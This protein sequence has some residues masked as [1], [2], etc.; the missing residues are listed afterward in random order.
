[1]KPQHKQ[2]TNQK[3]STKPKSTNIQKHNQPIQHVK[4]QYQQTTQTI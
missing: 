4:Q 2:A 3:P 1:M